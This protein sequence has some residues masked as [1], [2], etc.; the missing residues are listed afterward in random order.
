[1]SDIIVKFKPSGQKEIVTAI[2][3]IQAAEKNLTV[4][5]KRHNVVVANM[6]ASLKAQNKS[7][8]D[9][10]VSYNVVGKAAKGNR[11][12]MQQLTLAMKGA[13]KSSHGLLTSNRLLD[14][15]FATM[16]SHMLLFS[17]AMSLGV[18]QIIDFTKQ[19]AKVQG[20]E[21]AFNTLSGGAANAS[22]AINKLKDATDG[23]VSNFDLLQQANNAMIL[24]VTNNANVMADMFDMAQRLG[25][26]LGK[27]VGHSIE[28]LV[29]GM[30]RQSRLMLDNIGIIVKS[31][32][33]YK[34]Y[35]QEVGKTADTL[36]D[37]EKKQAF[38]EAA[39]DAA[40][41]KIKTLPP[42]VENANKTFQ[43]LSAS[44]SNFQNEIGTAFT[45]LIQ[46]IAKSMIDIADSFDA[47]RIKAF[48]AAMTGVLTAAMIAYR[49]VLID[50]IKKQTMLGWGALATAAG[51]LASEL[52][53]LTGIF[54]DQED[55]LDGV[56]GATE[57]YIKNLGDMKL[58]ELHAQLSL[59]NSSVGELDSSTS[60]LTESNNELFNSMSDI[61]D[62]YDFISK[63]QYDALTGMI[64]YSDKSDEL[65]NIQS[66]LGNEIDN[67]ATQFDKYGN[68]VEFSSET[69]QAFSESVE[70]DTEM[71]TA[72]AAAIQ[73][74]IRVI[75]GGFATYNAFLAAEDAI[76]NMYNKTTE[77]N[78]KNIEANI[79]M[80]E[81][82]IALEGQQEQY[83]AVLKKLQLQKAAIQNAETQ[84]TLQSYSRIAQ[85]T[86]TIAEHYK[87]SA[88]EVAFIQ[89]AGSVVDAFGA[90][91]SARF[92]AQKAGLPPPLPALAYGVELAAGLINA[93]KTYDAATKIGSGDSSVGGGGISD[94][95]DPVVGQFAEGGYVGGRP[96]SQ[97]G[98]LIEAERGEFVMSKNA[99]DSIG[100]ETLNQMNQSGGGGSVNVNVSGNVLTQ[101]FVEGE[102]AESIKEA[103]RRGSDFGLN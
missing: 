82:L 29:T 15:S 79:L 6:T 86:A 38:M 67:T 45:P 76:A 99:V 41:E 55:S 20:M 92:N 10:G 97:G 54:K 25:D 35:A 9:L 49:K 4:S 22:S 77:A 70:H 50:I 103:V 39:L 32:D 68:I 43:Q 89:A 51:I 72:N 34:K 95:T 102:L 16:R 36:T 101:D 88:K 28:S 71:A 18:R 66:N 93:K 23:T 44:M 74:R 12:A 75:E 7:W 69:L 1:M 40:R 33:A 42:E 17:F 80:I 47:E 30:G 14:N 59:A 73:E 19:A 100:L 58:G 57:T 21:R 2:K 53:V 65:I 87:A 31:N 91:A 84:A 3:A 52:I 98:T 64:I 48:A 94:T 81:S 11:V 62:G 85:G 63:E 26:A 46:S 24:G 61:N 27:D 8:R 83:T 60:N 78:E 13:K 5:G 96:H 90:A 56:S 37:Y